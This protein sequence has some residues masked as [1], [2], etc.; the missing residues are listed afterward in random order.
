MQY[1]LAFAIAGWIELQVMANL[2]L[3]TFAPPE[4]GHLQRLVTML[5]SILQQFRFAAFATS[6]RRH[7]LQSCYSARCNS[8]L[9]IIPEGCIS[10]NLQQVFALTFMILHVELRKQPLLQG[11]R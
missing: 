2:F 6:G 9:R 5:V 11:I 1:R 10:E 8:G 4:H 3:R 7:H